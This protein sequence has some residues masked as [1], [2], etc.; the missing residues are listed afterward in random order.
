M[1]ISAPTPPPPDDYVQLQFTTNPSDLADAA[2]EYLQTQWP[3]WMPNDGDPGVVLIESLAPMASNAADIAANMPP[4]ALIAFGTKLLGIPYQAGA[5]ATAT[6]TFTVQDANGPYVI[7][8][9]SEVDISGIAFQTTADL[10]IPNGSTT[11]QVAIA[12]NEVGQFA[13]NLTGTDWA[14]GSLPVYVTNMTL[15]APTTGGVD[16]QDDNDYLNMVSQEMQLRSRSIITLIDFEIVAVN[17]TGIGRAVAIAS[18]THP[19]DITVF[20]TDASGNPVASSIKTTLATQYSATRMVNATVAISDPSYTTVSVTYRALAVPA[21]DPTGLQTAINARLATELNPA[22]WGAPQSGDGLAGLTW[23][24]TP[25]V[26]VNRLIGVISGVGGVNYVESCSISAD[27]IAQLSAGLST[28][29]P[30]TSLPVAALE[31]TIASGATITVSDGGSNTQTWVTTA[32]ANPSDTTIAVTSQTP[33]FAYASGSKI[34][35]PVVGDLTMSAGASGALAKAGTMT[36]TID[37]PAT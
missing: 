35:G 13:N 17:T 5:S 21:A 24:D 16:Q 33:N 19:R 6:A 7:D 9:G 2:I 22:T 34:G 11:G 14:S 31:N 18:G 20:V 29:A 36:G 30:I 8:A 1:S 27:N 12:A 23:V 26:H 32:Q 25:V 10:T 28:G 4:A 15:V 37:V 3:D